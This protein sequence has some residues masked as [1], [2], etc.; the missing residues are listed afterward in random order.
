LAAVSSANTQDSNLQQEIKAPEI[1]IDDE[2]L[3]RVIDL[4]F[5]DKMVRQHLTAKDLNCA[6]T[7]YF[8]WEGAAILAEA[9]PDSEEFKQ[10]N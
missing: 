8:L 1:K 2:I 7:S 3:K 10:N 6:T 5:T 9:Q 4:G